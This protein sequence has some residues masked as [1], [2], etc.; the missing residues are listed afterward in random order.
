MNPLPLAAVMAVSIST[1]SLLS[2]ATGTVRGRIRYPACMGPPG[3]AIVCAEPT[4]GGMATCAPV[5]WSTRASGYDYRLELP[6]GDYYVYTR[7]ESMMPGYRAYF[8]RAVTCGLHTECADHTPIV[9]SVAPGR[10]V[11]DVDPADWYDLQ[12]ILRPT[13]PAS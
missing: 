12:G 8:T 10:V 7:T 4:A 1:L 9:V 13:T 5:A 11:G 6:A 2:M 3:D